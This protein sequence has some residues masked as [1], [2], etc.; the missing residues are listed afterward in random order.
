[1]LYEKINFISG[2]PLTPLSAK[3][4]NHMEAGIYDNSVAI[5]EIKEQLDEPLDLSAYAQKDELIT[6]GMVQDMIN[7]IPPTDLS[8][9]A[10]KD[11]V[12]NSINEAVLAGADVEVDLSPYA[13]HSDLAQK[14]DA[15]HGKG[16]SS[17]DYTNAEKEKL[18]SLKNFDS[19][20]LSTEISKKV[21]KV[22]G[23]QLSSNDFTDD[24]KVKLQNIKPPM[25]YY[26][27][28]GE[29]TYTKTARIECVANDKGQWTADFAHVGFTEPPHVYGLFAKNS[30]TADGD[31]V[32]ASLG[33]GE[34]TTTTASGTLSGAN[35]L[36]LLIGTTLTFR[37]G[38]LWII[39][40]GN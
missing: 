18:S 20:A 4:M 13:L 7:D 9:Y 12:R 8:L 36:G 28:T 25:K 26:N 15:E 32:F 39:L 17:N 35:G 21:D 5:Q 40:K 27:N 29:V 33:V 23:K 38:T 3:N 24:D 6:S 22:A 10:S 34:V 2:S 30:G 16:L 19:T 14:V 1:M 11:Y 37:S 31:R